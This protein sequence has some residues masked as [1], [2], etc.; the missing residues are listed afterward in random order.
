MRVRAMEDEK[1]GKSDLVIRSHAGGYER[2]LSGQRSWPLTPAE[3]AMTTEEIRSGEIARESELLFRDPV[4][5]MPHVLALIAFRDK[6]RITDH[7]WHRPRPRPPAPVEANPQ[8]MLYNWLLEEKINAYIDGEKIDK[9]F[10]I[11]IEYHDL[12]KKYHHARFLRDNVL[13]LVFDELQDRAEAEPPHNAPM[14]KTAPVA[15]KERAQEVVLQTVEAVNAQARRGRPPKYDWEFVEAFVFLTMKEKGDFEPA[16]SAWS[17]IHKL[18]PIVKEFCSDKFG[19]SPVDSMIEPRVRGMVA[20]W[21]TQRE[22]EKA[23]K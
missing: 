21:R 20:K 22:T 4:W 14:A 1:D 2:S 10:W 3:E 16:D 23:D 13:K 7:S 12:R 6:N 8:W 18:Y 9:G 17:G 11:S 15:P 5:D 19:R